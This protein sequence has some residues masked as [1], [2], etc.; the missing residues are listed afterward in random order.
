MYG[1]IVSLAILISVLLAEKAA[2]TQNKDINIFWGAA[3]WSILVGVIGARI[4]HV[5]DL[6]SYYA[7]NPIRIF[8]IWK[9]GLGIIGGIV[10]G[11]IA[12][13]F[14]LKIKRQNIFEWLNLAAVV[15]PLGQAM[16]RM[17]NVWNRELLPRAVYEMVYSSVMFMGLWVGYKY[18]SKFRNYT[19]VIYILGYAIIR[20]ILL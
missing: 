2:K 20:L 4:Y 15:L 5:V 6:F 10:L 18:F 16:G 14:Y 8:E 12:L 17:G 1:L 9:G 19:F 13:V 11:G 7:E 3:F